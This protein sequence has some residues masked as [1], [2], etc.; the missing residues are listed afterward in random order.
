MAHRPSTRL[1]LEDSSVNRKEPCWVDRFGD[2]VAS[3]IVEASKRNDPKATSC[4]LA[5]IPLE[6]IR[7]SIFPYLRHDR[8]IRDC[9]FVCG[10]V[11]VDYGPC[12]SSV[13]AYDDFSGRWRVYPRMNRS[14]AGAAAKAVDDYLYVIG[15]DGRGATMGSVEVYDPWINDWEMLEAVMKFPRHKHCLGLVDKRYLY[16]IGGILGQ[17]ISEVE[18]FDTRT[19]QWIQEPGRDGIHLPRALYAGRVLEKDGLLY[20]IGGVTRNHPEQHSDLIYVLDTTVIPHSWSVLSVRLSVG[21]SACAVAWLDESKSSIGIFGGYVVT[22]GR[23]KSTSTSEVIRLRGTHTVPIEEAAIPGRVVP[24]PPTMAIPEM[25]SARADC[26]AV[27]VGNCVVVVGGDKPA[28][29][30][31]DSVGIGLALTNDKALLFDSGRWDWVDDDAK[32]YMLSGRT[33][34]AVCLGSAFPTS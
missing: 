30:D 11:S 23:R 20:I 8:P 25:P 6:V 4:S 28:D 16:A 17:I 14:R 31:A 15:G 18:V 13:F 27:T 22:T 12:K 29:N 7:N 5:S 21:R 1:S 33:R 19:R 26:N 10:G 34:A 3:L 32:T 2:E 24:V 9:I